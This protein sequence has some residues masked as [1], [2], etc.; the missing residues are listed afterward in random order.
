MPYPYGSCSAECDRIIAASIAEA[1]TGA[2]QAHHSTPGQTHQ[3]TMSKRRVGGDNDHAGAIGRSKHAAFAEGSGLAVDRS[4][5]FLT[6]FELLQIITVQFHAHGCT[7]DLQC[8]PVI[9]LYQ[10][11]QQVSAQRRSQPARRR[12]NA[13]FKTETLRAG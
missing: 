3:I 1:G 9:R 8:P 10:H 11:T 2:R 12:P 7:A 5:A 13:A 4:R 6:T